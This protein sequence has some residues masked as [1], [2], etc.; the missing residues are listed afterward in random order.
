MQA[1]V[2]HSVR[3]G[4]QLEHWQKNDLFG[5]IFRPKGGGL[6]PRHPPPMKL[7]VSLV[8]G[9]G[10]GGRGVVTQRKIGNILYIQHLSTRPNTLYPFRL[11]G[12]NL[13]IRP[14]RYQKSWPKNFYD[15]I[16]VN[17]TCPFQSI[18]HF[19]PNTIVSPGQLGDELQ[20]RQFDDNE[21]SKW[22]LPGLPS[23]KGY[24]GQSGDWP[25]TA[26]G[27]RMTLDGRRLEIDRTRLNERK[28]CKLAI[29][30]LSVNYIWNNTYTNN[31]CL[32]NTDAS[33]DNK[34]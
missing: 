6:Q 20:W 3:K 2:H 26:C 24:I 16:R 27:Q 11:A 14:L 34:T 17:S 32:W 28:S 30:G 13:L 33:G 15:R 22:L 10:S 31:M 21:K 25:F 9:V 29:L 19:A 18:I 4:C 7:Q 23:D 1:F 5:K 8:S 12:S